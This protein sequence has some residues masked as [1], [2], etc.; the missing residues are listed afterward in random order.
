MV[1]FQGLLRSIDVGYFYVLIIFVFLFAWI[2]R[3]KMTRPVFVFALNFPL[4]AYCYFYFSFGAGPE[5]IGLVTVFM[6]LF[7]F[8]QAGWVGIIL[9][10]IGYF[11]RSN[12]YCSLGVSVSAVSVGGHAL[13]MLF[14]IFLGAGS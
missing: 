1:G 12:F 5:N 14:L 7:A 4:S 8:A 2:V 11:A 13:F 10:L 3:R 6:N 9:F